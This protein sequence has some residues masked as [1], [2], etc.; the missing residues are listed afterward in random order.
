LAQILDIGNADI[1]NVV[2]TKKSDH[3]FELTAGEFAKF[4]RYYCIRQENGGLSSV[5]DECDEVLVKNLPIPDALPF[6]TTAYFRVQ[7][8][9]IEQHD[10][11]VAS[12]VTTITM[13]YIPSEV[14]P[15][16]PTQKPKVAGGEAFG[17]T[18]TSRRYPRTSR[19]YPRTTKSLKK[20]VTKDGGSSVIDF[21]G[22]ATNVKDMD[23]STVSK[24]VVATA[25]YPDRHLNRKLTKKVKPKNRPTRERHVDTKHYMEMTR[26]WLI[27]EPSFQYIDGVH[28]WSYKAVE[29]PSI[30]GASF[31]AVLKSTKPL[32]KELDGST[33][34]FFLC[35]RY[36]HTKLIF[37]KTFCF[38]Q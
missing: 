35:S 31:W 2:R 21:Y 19:L 15:W 12:G 33:G 18:R 37:Q 7:R 23:A 24:V 34:L 10:K 26:Q 9:L 1:L 22:F 32:N 14:G 36:T 38:N 5:M 20:I 8:G 3:R 30:N 28:I 4:M 27:E 16:D 13:P 25:A 6:L 11:A 17:Y 29:F